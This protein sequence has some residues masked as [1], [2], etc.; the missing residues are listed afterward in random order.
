MSDKVKTLLEDLDSIFEA[1]VSVKK[2]DRVATGKFRNRPGEVKK[3][4]DGDQPKATIKLDDSKTPKGRRRKG[5]TKT[6]NL[7]PFKKL[8]KGDKGYEPRTDLPDDK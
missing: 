5:K 1:S 6:V 4:E 2:G 8:K 7:L 3:V